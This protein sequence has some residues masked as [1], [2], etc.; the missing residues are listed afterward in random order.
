MDRLLFCHLLILITAAAVAFSSTKNDKREILWQEEF[1]GPTLNLS[2]WKHFVT[3]W[4]GGND[5]FQYYND[6]QENRFD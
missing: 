3:G 4:R 1:D 2:A 5:E 6:Y